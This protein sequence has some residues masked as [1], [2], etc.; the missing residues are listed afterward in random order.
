MTI[1]SFRIK[2]DKT[3]LQGQNMAVTNTS[4]AIMN[5]VFGMCN[6]TLD[7]DVSMGDFSPVL[8]I[9]HV[10]V[11][12]H[13]QLHVCLD[14]NCSSMALCN[15]SKCTRGLIEMEGQKSVFVSIL[16]I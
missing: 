6:C 14:T 10:F 11:H 3:E 13:L 7:S 16:L 8:G 15:I 2:Q 4:V 5:F 1:V 12:V 9:S